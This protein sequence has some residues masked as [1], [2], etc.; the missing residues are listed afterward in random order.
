MRFRLDVPAQASTEI[1]RARLA[2]E[3]WSTWWPGARSGHAGRVDLDLAGPRP[4]RVGLQVVPHAD[5]AEVA[6]VEGELSACT[7]VV[8]VGAVVSADV[9]LVFP[10]AI[11]AL[12]RHDL[13]RW[14]RSR[15]A[16]LAAPEPASLEPRSGP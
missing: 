9:E 14:L 2:P 4:L 15:L 16:L 5:G 11:P 12:L 6:M 1:I 3:R 7:V 10:T 13:E 8:T